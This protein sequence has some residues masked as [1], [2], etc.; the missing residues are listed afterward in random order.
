MEVVFARSHQVTPHHSGGATA[1]E[2]PPNQLLGWFLNMKV[3]Y[4]ARVFSCYLT[5]TVDATVFD[6]SSSGVLCANPK[7]L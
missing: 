1:N 7:H 5:Q 6:I 3:N 4:Q 2:N